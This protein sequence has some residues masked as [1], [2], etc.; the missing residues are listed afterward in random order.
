MK[1]PNFGK[2]RDIRKWRSFCSFYFVNV[3]PIMWWIL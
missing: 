2:D 3:S 1:N